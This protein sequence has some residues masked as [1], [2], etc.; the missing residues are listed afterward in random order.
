MTPEA[1]AGYR[2]AQQELL[3]KAATLVRLGGRLIYVTCSLLG[4]E[5]EDQVRNFLETHEEFAV[6]P[7]AEVWGRHMAAP[8]PAT[9]PYLTL[10]PAGQGTDGFF[11]AL[12]DRKAPA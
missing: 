6:H 1:L 2:A 3:A 7:V 12:L 9:G 8:C 11:V 10:T 5:N 4:E